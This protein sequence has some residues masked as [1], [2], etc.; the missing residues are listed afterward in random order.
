MKRGAC[1]QTAETTFEVRHAPVFD[2][3]DSLSF[4]TIEIVMESNIGTP[5]F[6]YIVDDR[7]D[8]NILEPVKDSLEY[9]TH[10]VKVID[11]AGCVIDTTFITNAPGFDFPIHI[12]PNNDGVN[13]AFSIPILRK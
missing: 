3:I 6:Q 1:T 11:A 12:S 2:R 5:P 8:G 10:T 4:R 7:Q 13:D 9:G